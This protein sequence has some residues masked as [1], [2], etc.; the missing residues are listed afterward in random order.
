MPAN[1]VVITS[2]FFTQQGDAQAGVK[3]SAFH[4]KF[5]SVKQWYE[6]QVFL[7]DPFKLRMYINMRVKM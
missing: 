7:H 6:V 4:L 3:R 5:F 1:E 2:N